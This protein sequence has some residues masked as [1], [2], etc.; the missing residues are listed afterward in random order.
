MA[1]SVEVD[2]SP[3]GRE[4]F[5]EVYVGDPF[6]VVVALD[7]SA[8]DVV[9]GAAF[10]NPEPSP[11]DIS[12]ERP[13]VVLRRGSTTIE[14]FTLE[15]LDAKR[16]LHHRSV[17]HLPHDEDV[18]RLGER[19]EFEFWLTIDDQPP[20][21]FS[22]GVES[23]TL[24]RSNRAT[25]RLAEIPEDGEARLTYLRRIVHYPLRYPHKADSA[26]ADLERLDPQ[27]KSG[28]HYE[29]DA[30]VATQEGKGPE[31]LRLFEKAAELYLVDS[32]LPEDRRAAAIER[33]SIFS[34]VYHI[35]QTSNGRYGLTLA[36]GPRPGTEF[37][38]WFDN[39]E[40]R[41]LAAIDP[42]NPA[43]SSPLLPNTFIDWKRMYEQEQRA[44]A[45][46]AEGRASEAL[47]LLDEMIERVETTKDLLV[48]ERT[49]R[50]VIGRYSIFRRVFPVYEASGGRYA[51]TL[52]HGKGGLKH[53]WFDR[54]DKRRL[55]PIDPEN[56][57]ENAPVPLPS[58][59]E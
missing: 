20:G 51:V 52:G 43:A 46:I 29:R 16:T 24:D 25:F 37:Y 3:P 18:I 13:R 40:G 5:P 54:V 38:Y 47:A 30:L 10:P 59:I 44:M 23:P 56:P 15:A 58:D 31:A 17:N 21:T 19:A 11:Y 48:D 7:H 4:P 14:V 55:E 41:R 2:F 33:T 6:R 42:S 8:V 50:M 49:K 35:Y 32:N 12:A 28:G 9:E 1:G 26:R 39:H 57:M 45:L 36:S 22:L 27:P 34:E 53:F